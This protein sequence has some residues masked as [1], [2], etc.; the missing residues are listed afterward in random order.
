MSNLNR[1]QKF[2]NHSLLLLGGLSGV[3]TCALLPLFGLKFFLNRSR[4]NFINIIV[5]FITNLIQLSLI[6][7]SKLN[8]LHNFI[9]SFRNIEFLFTF[10]ISFML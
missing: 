9:N 6:I 1:K 2:L 10:L 3:Y 8:N 5:L 4:Y 7:I